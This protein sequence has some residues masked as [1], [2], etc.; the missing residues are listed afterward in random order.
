MQLITEKNWPQVVLLLSASILCGLIGSYIFNYSVNWYV[1]SN[2]LL[3]TQFTEKFTTRDRVVIQ[4]AKKVVVEQDASVAEAVK[5]GNGYLVGIYKKNNNETYDLKQATGQAVILSADGWLLTANDK[6]VNPTDWQAFVAI[7][8]QGKIYQLQQGY[9]DKNSGYWL[10]KM[11]E[12]ASLPVTSFASARDLMA[13]QIIVAVGWQ[14]NPI[15][16]YYRGGEYKQQVRFSDYPSRQLLLSDNVNGLLLV[17]NLSKQVVGIV[18]A[19]GIQSLDY[20]LPLINNLSLDKVSRAT[21]GVYYKDL[22]TTIVK[23]PQLGVMITH[24]DKNPAVQ[25]GS[26]AERAGL[27]EGDIILSVDNVE[28]NAD[29]DLAEIIS[30]YKPGSKL[31][32]K[33]KQ[34]QAEKIIEIKLD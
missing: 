10:V 4:D 9:K 12:A 22:S 2:N 15:I 30:Q 27:K 13:G 7:D 29:N 16:T 28:L 8:N 24:S 3:S 23:T 14:K 25:K 1:N 5:S 11:A 34:G 17:L 20:Y 26:V 31:Y 33:V 32:L 19:R 6:I 18:D 21:L